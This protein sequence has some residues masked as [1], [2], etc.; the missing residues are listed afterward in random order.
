MGI[1]LQED[2]SSSVDGGKGDNPAGNVGA[3]YLMGV[4]LSPCMCLFIVRKG[5]FSL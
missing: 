2:D 5:E 1:C 4:V 3:N